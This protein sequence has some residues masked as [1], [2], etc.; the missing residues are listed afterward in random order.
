MENHSF[1]GVG[2][3]CT[4][5]SAIVPKCIFYKRDGF[6]AKG[7]ACEYFHDDG[8]VPKTAC[9]NFGTSSGCKFGDACRFEHVRRSAARSP[10]SSR[11]GNVAISSVG[12]GICSGGSSS[13]SDSGSSSTSSNTNSVNTNPAN[14]SNSNVAVNAWGFV[15]EEPVYFY[16]APG[17]FEAPAPQKSYADATGSDVE[18]TETAQ[19]ILVSTSAG[20]E[21]AKVCPFFFSS[22][23]KF[24]SRCKYSHSLSTESADSGEAARI[25]T[26]MECGI[27][28]GFP[29]NGIYGLLN[30]C[31]CVFCLECIRGWRSEGLAIVH[32]NS[33]VR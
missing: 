8:S 13:S 28:M 4:K 24:G 18:I 23:C 32:E 11:V 3:R 25:S 10:N 29:E 27:C 1:R 17:T 14:S 12:A 22:G 33:Q 19:N 5:M 9:K 31:S 20:N 6:C 21:D 2:R 30:N 7:S 26:N 15:D 16:G